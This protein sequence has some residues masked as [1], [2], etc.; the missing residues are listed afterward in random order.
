MEIEVKVFG[1]KL[2]TY[3]LQLS[4]PYPLIYEVTDIISDGCAVGGEI[5]LLTDKLNEEDTADENMEFAVTEA[6][7]V[8]PVHKNDDITFYI[9]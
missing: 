9:I 3:W 8:F 6:C 1:T 4:I 7:T 2:L 5:K